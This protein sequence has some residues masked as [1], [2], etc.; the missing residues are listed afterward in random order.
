MPASPPVL[1]V[2]RL[3]ADVERKVL[4]LDHMGKLP[5]HRKRKQYAEV[6]N[7]YRCVYWDVEEAGP[8]I[9]VSRVCPA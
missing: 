5:A 9:S 1:V 4:V 3:S 7:Q 2:S 8:P 6:D